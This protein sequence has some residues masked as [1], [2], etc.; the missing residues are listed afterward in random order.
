M[1]N[2][3]KVDVWA[4]G[5]LLYYLYEGCYPFKGYNEKELCR[6]ITLGVFAFRKCHPVMQEVIGA[7]LQSDPDQRLDAC[8][9]SSLVKKAVPICSQ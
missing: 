9:L 8:D 2:P 1:Y 5:V 6:N 7:A 4:L 3:F